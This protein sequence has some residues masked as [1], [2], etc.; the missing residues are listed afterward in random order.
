MTHSPI[1]VTGATGR[2]GRQ[3]V[4]QLAAAGHAVRAVIRDPAKAASLP[5]TVEV[6]VADLTDPRSLTAAF[7]GAERRL[8]LRLLT[9]AP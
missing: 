6:V 3:L 8:A 9:R 7:D 5:P 1:L 2:V 4:A